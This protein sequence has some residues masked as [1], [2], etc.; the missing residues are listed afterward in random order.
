MT[1]EEAFAHP[2][3][4]IFFQEDVERTRKQ[5]RKALLSSRQSGTTAS[6]IF[7]LLAEEGHLTSECM[8]HEAL[9]IYK[10]QSD[11]PVRMR[12]FI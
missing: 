8:I 2:Q 9:L 1:Y 11:L 7:E 12:D 3:F 4:E 10:K 6:R 5:I